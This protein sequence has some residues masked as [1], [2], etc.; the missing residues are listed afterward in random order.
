[1]HKYIQT[2]ILYTKMKRRLLLGRLWN[3]GIRGEKCRRICYVVISQSL[4]GYI[5]MS[6]FFVFLFSSSSSY[7][8][9]VVRLV[10]MEGRRI[11]ISNLVRLLSMQIIY[12]TQ[13]TTLYR[14]PIYYYYYYLYCILFYRTVYFSSI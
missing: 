5:Y 12:V 11:P 3:S 1:M 7:I 13:L 6:L 10:M 8:V 4:S 9:N 14:S 2:R